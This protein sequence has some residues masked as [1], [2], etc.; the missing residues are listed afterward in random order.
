[1]EKSDLALAAGFCIVVVITFALHAKGLWFRNRVE[2][3]V[4]F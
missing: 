3:A 1:M 2:T 4:Q